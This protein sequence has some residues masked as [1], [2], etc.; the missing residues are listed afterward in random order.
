MAFSKLINGQHPDDDSFWPNGKL[1]S[2]IFKE[3]E[4]FRDFKESASSS[5]QTKLAIIV[6][7]AKLS[8][9]RSIA[10]FP[11]WLGYVGLVFHHCSDLVA[12]KIISDSILPQFLVLVEND[13]EVYRHLQEKKAKEELL[14]VHD[15]SLIE[16]SMAPV[17]KERL[18]RW[19][20]ESFEKMNEKQLLGFF[21]EVVRNP[22]LQESFAECSLELREEFERRGYD[23]SS[24][25]G[26]NGFSFAKKIKIADKKIVVDEEFYRILSLLK[27]PASAE[28]SDLKEKKIDE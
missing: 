20:K 9:I 2:D 15:L 12:Q 1:D 6:A 16:K 4:T 26:K 11:D 28:S 22:T 27:K 17:E 7:A 25:S 24:I 19:Y 3:I 13:K 10:R 21:N 14:D 8:D 5:A 23:Y 18:C